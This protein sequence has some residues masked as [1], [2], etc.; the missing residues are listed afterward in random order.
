LLKA[1]NEE[2]SY[3]SLETFFAA[4]VAVEALRRGGDS[5]REAFIRAL[6][7]T[8]DANFDGFR[9]HFGAN[10]R[11]AMQFVELTVLV[12]DGKVRY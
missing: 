8:R 2:P 4:R 3:T 7:S 9:V 1:K 5:S 12:R 11:N 6:E 10:D